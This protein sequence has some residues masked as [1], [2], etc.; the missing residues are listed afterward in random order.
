M[1]RRLVVSSRPNGSSFIESDGK[2]EHV[3]EFVSVPGFSLTLLWA[4]DDSSK[5]LHPTEWA[6]KN[7]STWVPPAGGH[8]FMLVTFPPDA[9]MMSP[10]FDMNAAGLEY[11]EKI[12]GLA[13]KFEPNCPGMHTTDT[14]DYSIVLSGSISLDIGDG[15]LNV[16]HQHDITVLKGARHA[17]RNHTNE[18]T[19]MM[20]V[21]NGAERPR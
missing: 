1:T 19:Q 9:V 6:N 14:L 17:W 4:T 18:P 3:S 11:F 2:P 13:E 16:L 21:L 8:R 12:P 7:I 5:M 20:F 15:S 10:E